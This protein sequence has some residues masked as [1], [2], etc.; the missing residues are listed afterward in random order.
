ML[1]ADETGKGPV[2]PED[3]TFAEWAK[4]TGELPPDFDK[5]PHIVSLPDPLIIDEGGKNI[6]VKTRKQWEEKRVMM[7]KEIRHYILGSTPPSPQNLTH[8]VLSERKD[9]AVTLRTVELSFGPAR[10]A[11]LTVELMIP[12]GQGPLPVFLTQWNHRE[13]AQIA[14]RRGYIGCVYAAADSKDD[15]EAYSK[16]WWPDYDFSRLMRRAFGTSRVIDYLETL[17]VVDKMKIALTGHSRNGKMSLMAAALD[18]RIAAVCPSSSGTGGEVP[19]RYATHPYDIEDLALLTCAQPSWFHPRLRYFVG[20][21]DQLPIDQNSLMALVAPRG[22]MLSTAIHES[23]S[24]PWGI[25]QA[26]LETRKVY[27]FLG[28]S[29]NLAIRSRDGKHGVSA[30]DIEE[31]IDFFDFVFKRSKDKPENR[32][33]YPFSFDKWLAA[34][35]EKP[36]SGPFAGVRKDLPGTDDLKK[37]VS[38]KTWETRRSDI[39]KRLEWTLGEMPP[40]VTNE[41]PGGL[42]KKGVGEDSFGTFIQRPNETA[43]MKIMPVSPY[44]GFGDN[45]FGSLYYPADWEK[46]PGRK[47]LPVLIYLHEYDYSKGFGAMGRDH[48]ISSFFAKM[49]AQGYAVF[50]YDMIGMGNRIEEGTRFYDRYPK[51]SKMGKMVAD[52]TGA[53]DALTRMDLLDP[54]RVYVGGYA[55]GGTVGLLAAALDERIAGA[56]SVSGITPLASGQMLRHYSHLHGLMPRLGLQARAPFDFD[57]VLAMIAPR[58]V[59][60]VTPRFDKDNAGAD[61][62][63]CLERAGRVYAAHGKETELSVFVPDDYNRF[64]KENQEKVLEWLKGR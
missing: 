16:I 9:G 21:E 40:G 48:E 43:G 8:R 32:L 37:A 29:A 53:V 56:V 59:L 57:E 38:G 58:P 23:A 39:R 12:P 26:F 25:E 2:S 18:Q 44:N 62:E 34:S 51:W 45:L 7:E 11:K 13:W 22:L 27:D 5:L 4:R 61:L 47:P 54:K 46:Q 52:V 42:A 17:P 31:Y 30:K 41:G 1:P 3:V 63:N 50:S 20:R 28:G 55:L 36:G 35:L 15:T 10:Q 60:A 24:N 64:S 14:V 19:W 6:P 49:V 33:N